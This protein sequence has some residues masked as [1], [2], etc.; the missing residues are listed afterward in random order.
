MIGRSTQTITSGPSLVTYRATTAMGAG[1]LS[2]ARP[3]G[4][5]GKAAAGERSERRR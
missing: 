5:P 2:F 3:P 1:Y 4:A